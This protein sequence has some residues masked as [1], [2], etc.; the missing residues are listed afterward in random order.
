MSSAPEVAFAT[1]ILVS[2]VAF[3]TP[4]LLA[5]LGHPRSRHSLPFVAFTVVPLAP[6]GLFILLGA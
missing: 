6:L 4:I 5:V 2:G 3:A 1:S